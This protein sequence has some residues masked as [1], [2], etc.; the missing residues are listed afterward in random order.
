MLNKKGNRKSILD[1]MMLAAIFIATAYWILDSILNI[2]FFNKYNIIAELIGADLYN[3]YIRVVVLC[4]FIIFGSH[5]QASINRF[6]KTQKS[7]MEGEER[8]RTLFEYNPIET[9][10]V[11]HDARVTGYNLAKTNSGDKVP[12]IGDIMYKDYAGK[13]NINM[14]NELM[15]CIRSNISKEFPEQKYNGNFLYIRIAPFSK[16]A[17]ITA[18]NITKQKQLQTQLQQAQKMDAIST[19]AGGIAHQ[20]NNILSGIT[21]NTELLQIEYEGDKKI[22][23]FSERL[24]GLTRRMTGLT[25]QLLAY[26]RGGKY[27]ERQLSVCQL[28]EETLPLIKHSINRSIKVV[29]DLKKDIPIIKADATQLQMVFSAVMSNA[30][31]AI[32]ES[33][34]IRV[35]VQKKDVDAKYAMRHPGLKVGQYVR[36]TVEDDGKGLDK[37]SKERIFEPFY[38]TK[39]QGRGLGMA[40]SY[41]AIINHGGWIEIDSEPGKGAVV[42]I[43]LP[44]SADTEEIVL[45]GEKEVAE[46]S[47]GKG[48]I[49]IIDDEEEVLETSL[50]ALEHLGYRVLT[51]KTG[52]EAISIVET[53]GKDIDL[54]ILDIG[55]PDIRGDIVCQRIQELQPKIKV[56]VSTGYMVE[57]ITDDLKIKAQ[58]FIQKPFSMSEM[59]MKLKDALSDK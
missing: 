45:R 14:Y 47:K 48:T 49:L 26:A 9:I 41:G 42:S 44:V 21:G 15:E 12:Q 22:K 16:G 17:I 56:V 4:L 27:Q 53:A 8:Y 31:E 18:L 5:A 6:K 40:A 51:A 34:S 25:S 1:S 10:T 35:A 20:F 30:S 58:S 39:L 28:V 37:E 46:I 7:L 57:D 59:A 24:F 19:L 32:E 54:A 50:L 13:H 36:L 11:D 55:L 52:M 2:F 3:I 38:S 43:Y 23:E 33:G 29:T